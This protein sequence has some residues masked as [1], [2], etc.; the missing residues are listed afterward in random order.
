MLMVARWVIVGIW[1][2][3]LTVR[4]IVVSL[5]PDADLTVFGIAEGVSIAAGLGVIG[6]AVLR[7][8]S[9]RR[10]HADEALARAIRGVDPTVW[11]VPAAP[12]PELRETIAAVRP[13]SELRS[14]VTWAFGATEASLWELDGRRATRLLV[15]RWSRVMHV[16][17]EDLPDPD[18]HGTAC[19]VALHHVRPDDTTAVAT[20]FVRTA[21]GSDRLLRRGR[22]LDDLLARLARERIIA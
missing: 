17:L 9:L 12:T 22:R 2:A 13:D 14:R 8:R 5:H 4:V 18:G 16:G 7:A 20:F 21:P 10:R 1:V 6:F 15:I 11:I 3:L 19:A